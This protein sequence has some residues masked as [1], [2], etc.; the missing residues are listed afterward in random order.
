MMIMAMKPM[1]LTPTMTGI[2]EKAMSV[3]M[4][5]DLPMTASQTMA[6]LD[7]LVVLGDMVVVSENWLS[8]AI[9]GSELDARVMLSMMIDRLNLI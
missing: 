3:N 9:I 8:A 4:V 1:M 6:D 5:P 7:G 2:P